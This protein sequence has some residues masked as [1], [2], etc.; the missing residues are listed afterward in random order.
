MKILFFSQYFWPENF[1]INELVDYFKKKF[2]STVLT[3]SPSYPTKKMYKNFKKKYDLNYKYLEI[4]RFPVYPRNL[5]NTS[6]KLNYLSFIIVSFFYSFFLLIK[7]KF[8]V[9][10]IFC[11][12]PIF[13]SIP[14]ILLNKIF[15][16]KIVIW[17]LDLWPETVI[18]LK[19][20]K[21]K[22]LIYVLK[23]I[24]LY[25]YNN[26]DLILA[27]SKSI[28]LAIRKITKTK[29]IYFP[30]W[31]EEKIGKS[32][33]K[34]NK[35]KKNKHTKIIFAGNIG[36]SQSFITLVNA[37]KLLKKEKLQWIVIGEGR[38][39][40]KLKEL[41]FKNN[42]EK[43]ILLYKNIPINK[44]R[45]YLNHA[46]ALYLSLKNNKTFSKTIPG[47][48]QTYMSLKKPIIASISGETSSIITTSKSGLVSKAEDHRALANNV[49]KFLT[50]S[51]SQKSKFGKNSFEYVKRNFSK[52]SILKNLN[53]EILNFSKKK[54]HN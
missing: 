5:T 38:W 54:L 8:D 51:K 6:I 33:K 42:L 19:I 9:I 18:D 46:D 21:N 35:I 47:K 14:I 4:I 11:P 40:K 25:I 44:I 15:K 32:K 23:K 13:S 50:F 41:I 27:Q 7:K 10:F 37:A 26:A 31:P 34:T 2:Q 39:K 30:S 53:Q 16:K 22:F 52:K 17:I 24:S 29:C 49:M 12:S 20:V 43:N 45:L 48:L 28:N 1:R 3:S 36:E